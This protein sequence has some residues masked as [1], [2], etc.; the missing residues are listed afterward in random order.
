MRTL[1]SQEP[2]V[3][4]WWVEIRGEMG[5][6]PEKMRIAETVGKKW[7]LVRWEIV[8]CPDDR[9]DVRRFRSC[10]VPV[11]MTASAFESL[12]DEVGHR[13]A[14]SLASWVMIEV[15]CNDPLLY[16]EFPTLGGEAVL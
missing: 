5:I 2:G 15:R 12:R 6:M 16:T 11:S 8:T 14:E 1:T 3:T 7:G 4:G 9:S 13:L 10:V